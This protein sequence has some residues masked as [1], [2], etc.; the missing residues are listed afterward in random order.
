MSKFHGMIVAG[1][2]LMWSVPALAEDAHH[3]AGTAPTAPPAASPMPP[4]PQ[5]MMGSGMMSMM[6]GGAMAMMGQMMAPE[7]IEGRI[8]F[9]K[10]ELKITAAQEPLWS[11]FAEA[12]RANARTMSSRQGMMTGGHGAASQTLPQRIEGHERALSEH[13]DALRQLKAALQP[14]YAALDAAQK[15]T[16]DQLLLPGPM[17]RM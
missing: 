16:A 15:Q 3:P 10:T 12:L 14:L 5:S 9:L 11:A 1:T 4:A 17:R 2:L 6:N 7:R 8:A 13:L